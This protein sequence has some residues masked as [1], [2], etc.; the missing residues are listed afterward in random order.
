MKEKVYTLLVLL[1]M[2]LGM[3]ACSEKAPP[4]PT[5]TPNPAGI[6]LVPYTSQE[7]GISGVVPDGWVELKPGQFHPVMSRSDPTLLVQV[8]LP[9]ATMEQV[10]NRAGFP[11]SVGSMETASLTWDLYALEIEVR[12]EGGTMVMDVALTEADAGVYVVVLAALAD[13][14]AALYDAVFV[15]AV[16]A[17]VPTVVTDEDAEKQAKVRPTAPPAAGAAP[18]NTRVRS[19]DGMVM[20]YVPDG[21]FGMGNDGIRWHWVGTLRDGS[22]GLASFT[23]EQPRH[24]VYLDAFWID[25]TEVTVGMFRKFV[26]ATGY[27]TAAER[28]DY[29]QP[30]K[31]GPKEDEWPRVPG[32][33]WQHPRG[34][35]SKAEDD[36]PVV[37]VTWDD[38]AAYCAWV[39]GALP[40][41]AQWEKACRGAD[42]RMYPWGDTFDNSRLNYCD[43]LCPVERWRD[44]TYSDGYAY[45]SPGG[46]YP[47]AGSAYG[48]MAMAGNV[49]EWMA[50]RYDAEYYSDSPYEN[51]LGPESGK[52][53]TQ[54]G[55]AWYDGEPAGWTTCTVRHATPPHNRA[56]DLGFRCAVPAQKGST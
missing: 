45:T 4:T 22:L 44:L 55:G 34:P 47:E 48:A 6:T 29:G 17:L 46:S 30:Y 31:A 40:T 10:M 41:E 39:G 49:W 52:H 13:R 37:Q 19:A 15:P 26:E 27:A 2:V 38:A 56:D 18:I 32:A 51:P 21:E 54:R 16:E 28:E 1:A 35:G 36:H 53:R 42:S 50:D 7:L 25:Q 5:A 12:E 24:T 8:T 9:G 23:D 33:D 3:A 43:S 20:V 14:H 11:E